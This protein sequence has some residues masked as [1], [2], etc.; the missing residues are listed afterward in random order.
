MIRKPS[1]KTETIVPFSRNNPDSKWKEE[2]NKRIEDAKMLIV[3]DNE[4]IKQMLV[5]I[6]SK[7]SIKSVR[8]PTE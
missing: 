1:S 2:D 5:G 4:S 6:F 7:H 8:L 3:E